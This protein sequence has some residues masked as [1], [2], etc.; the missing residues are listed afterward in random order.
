MIQRAQ[1]VYFLLALLALIPL[2]IWDIFTLQSTSSDLQV[3]YSVF[4]FQSSTTAMKNAYVDL[5]IPYA[6][7]AVV[8][9][10]C[11]FLF[12]NRKMQLLLGQSI[13][14]ILILTF[15]YQLYLVDLNEAALSEAFKSALEVKID[16]HW[17]YYA[18]VFAVV[19]L[20]LANR[21]VR[22]DEALVK[23]LDRLR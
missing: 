23:S 16:R 3:A 10:T 18:P 5:Y 19:M 12:K 7:V 21:G 20:F 1:T 8:I 6:L 9:L 14:Y 4:G 17:N 13:Y 22:K 11:I 2:F 15:I